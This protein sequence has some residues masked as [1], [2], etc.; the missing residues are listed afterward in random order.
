MGCEVLPK[1]LPNADDWVF[2]AAGVPPQAEKSVDIGIDGFREGVMGLGFGAVVVVDGSGVAQASLE[3]QASL[4]FE[5]LENAL[6][7]A[8]CT[9]AAG[10]E[11]GCDGAAGAERLKAE[12][13]F[14]DG[15]DAGAGA[16][17]FFGAALGGVGSEKSKRSF[18]ALVVAGLV[19]AGAGEDAK[20]KSPKSLEPLGA[21]LVWGACGGFDAI[22][23]FEASFGPASKKPPPLRCGDVTCGAATDD[24]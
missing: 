10:F 5:K 12:L 16:G 6:V 14:T 7:L 19:G 17:A 1:P 8:G 21:R 11:A 24:L 4:L 23:G 20:L 18:E 13:M 3:P 15:V 22:A 9:D 2:E